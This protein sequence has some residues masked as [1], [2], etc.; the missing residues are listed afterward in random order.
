MKLLLAFLLLFTSLAAEQSIEAPCIQGLA[1]LNGCEP[2]L[3]GKDLEELHTVYISEVDVPGGPDSLADLLSLLYLNQPLDEETLSHLKATILSHYRDKHRRIVQV[4]IPEQEVTHG[5]VQLRI[6][7]GRLGDVHIEGA[8]WTNKSLLEKQFGI[9]SGDPIDEGRILLSLNVMNRNPFHRVSAIYDPGKELSLT[10]VTLAVEDRR[11]FRV[12]AAGENNGIRFAGRQ[13]WLAG[14]NWGNVFGLNHL[15]TYQYITA[16]SLNRFQAHTV[17]YLAPLSNNHILSVYGGYSYLHPEVSGGQSSNGYSG[18]ASFRYSIPFAIGEGKSHEFI[19]GGDYKTTNT[20]VEYLDVSFAPTT[21]KVNLTQL[22]AGYQFQYLG[23]SAKFTAKGE[24]LGS[25]GSWLPDQSNARYNKLRAGATHRWLYGRALLDY[26][27]TLPYSFTLN[28]HS[29]LQ[30]AT[31]NLLPSEQLGIG[32]Y[33]TVRGYE[34]RLLSKESGALASL[35]LRSPPLSIPNGTKLK[36]TL[37]FLAFC[38]Y[39]WGMNRTQIGTWERFDS[40]LSVGP[41]LRYQLA[42]YLQ[43]RA[44]WGFRL[45][46]VESPHTTIGNFLHFSLSTA[47]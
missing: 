8:R 31:A 29:L 10:D 13:R 25:P 14:L 44:D 26:I 20:V 22:M 23:A 21:T 11:P 28:L 2:L 32:G 41:G 40:L 39:G 12:Y 15:F 34:E 4:T 24:L 1:I 17:Q 45:L 5:V 7:E 6:V 19:F 30:Y 3:E 37:L 33:D 38:D 27:Q 35:E 16:N 42:D 43:V 18:Q 36:G 46:T 9:E 47:Y